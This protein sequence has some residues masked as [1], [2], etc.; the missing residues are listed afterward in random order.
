MSENLQGRIV[1]ILDEQRLVANIGLQDGVSPGDRFVVFETGEE[2]VDPESGESL[3]ELELVKA[4][5]EAAH[6]QERMVIL[7][8]PSGSEQERPIAKTV[9]SAIMAQTSPGPDKREAISLGVRKDQISGMPLVH[10]IQVGDQV[11]RVAL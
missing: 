6:V 9:L 5:V 11:R 8:A 7:A 3:G 2:I 10:P 1:K 4:Q